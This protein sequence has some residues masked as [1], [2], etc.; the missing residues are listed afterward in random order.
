MPQPR[1]QVLS[2]TRRSVGLVGENLGN[3]VE[4]LNDAVKKEIFFGGEDIF[5]CLNGLCNEKV[6]LK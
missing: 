5:C 6:L 3:E 2:P 4:G 1:S